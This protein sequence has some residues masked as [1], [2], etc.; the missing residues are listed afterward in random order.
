MN[1]LTNKLETPANINSFI[2]RFRTNLKT[3]LNA[4]T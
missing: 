1:E 3:T 2:I 4:F